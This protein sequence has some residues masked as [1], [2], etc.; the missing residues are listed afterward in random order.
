MVQNFEGITLAPLQVYCSAL[1][2]APEESQVRRQLAG[3][4]FCQAQI[5][6]HAGNNYSALLRALDNHTN[7]IMQ[8]AFSPDS[9]QLA[10]LSNRGY[11]VGRNDRDGTTYTRV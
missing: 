9:K 6:P 8:V 1:L 2:F 11:A 7:L 3:E 4:M 10:S 5:L